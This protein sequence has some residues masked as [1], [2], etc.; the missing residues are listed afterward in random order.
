MNGSP[1]HSHPL[2]QSCSL[3]MVACTVP[4]FSQLG[5]PCPS[6]AERVA[7]LLK[8]LHHNRRTSLEQVFSSAALYIFSVQATS[9]TRHK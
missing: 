3:Q 5:A 1:H 7:D 6:V 2:L 8:L 4:Y 9:N